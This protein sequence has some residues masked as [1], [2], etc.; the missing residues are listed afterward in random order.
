[1]EVPA[2]D[3][4]NALILAVQLEGKVAFELADKMLA[5]LLQQDDIPSGGA[6]KFVAPSHSSRLEW[7][8]DPECSFEFQRQALAHRLRAKKGR[9]SSKVLPVV[10]GQGVYVV[11]RNL[12]CNTRHT[13]TH[14]HSN[15]R[16]YDYTKI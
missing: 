1:M 3:K 5:V 7:P 10:D 14:E 8:W 15:T 6:F 16:R 11:H 2:T 9:R 13:H 4:G 12:N